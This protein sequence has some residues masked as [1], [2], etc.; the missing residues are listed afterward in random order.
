[1]TA[2]HLFWVIQSGTIF[3]PAIKTLTSHVILDS[4]FLTQYAN[5][6]PPSPL[7][8]HN[9]LL[10]SNTWAAQTVKN[11]PATQETQVWS[12]DGEDP[13]EKG[14]ALT[15]VF[16]PGESH[17]QR[18]LVGY[19]PWGHKESDTTERL[20]HVTLTLLVTQ[21]TWRPCMLS[22]TL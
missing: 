16:L 12:L 10:P 13:L 22:P 11:L 5:F 2:G 17:G 6:L 3:G 18:S 19:R 14:M 15:P 20:T 9:C 7:T 1:M 21:D 4:W 8:L